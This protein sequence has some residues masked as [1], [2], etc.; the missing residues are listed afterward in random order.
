MTP[1]ITAAVLYVLGFA[2]MALLI[3][4]WD[5]K[6]NARAVVVIIF[7]PAV[8]FAGVVDVAMTS[9]HLQREE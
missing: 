3:H 8:A 7:W 2:N 4:A 1:W 9:L 6:I 5:R